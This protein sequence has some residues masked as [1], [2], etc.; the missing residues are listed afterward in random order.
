VAFLILHGLEG[1]GP[2]HWQ[3]WIAGRL[4]DR[5]HEVAYPDL[6]DADNPRLGPW[7]DA[8]DAELARV[9]AAET[10]VLCHSLGSLLW[11]HHAARRPAEPVARALLVAPP[12]PDEDDPQSPGFRPVPLD[13]E[14]VAAAARE[15][16]LVCSTDD[17]WCPPETSSQV[18]RETGVEIEWI[19]DAGHVNTAAGFGPWP[20]LEGW[21]LG[22][23]DRPT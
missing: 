7:L 19:E 8:L 10:T 5:G 20:E 6:P 16:L 22:E 14:G 15:T 23:R 4:R 17:P 9:P 2:E 11:L 12:Q 1:S 18:G 13:R 3:S 21:A